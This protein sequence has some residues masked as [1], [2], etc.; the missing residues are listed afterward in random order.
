MLREILLQAWIA[1][2]R[3]PT[4]SLLTMTGIVW[5]IITVTMLVAY[6]SGFRYILIHAFE[7]FGKSVVVCWPG[8]TSEQV[9]GERAGK[10]VRFQREDLEAVRA[11]ATLVRYACLET[12]RQQ[13]VQYGERTAMRPVRG[14]CAEYGEMRSEVPSDGR[15]I[16]PEDVLERRRVVFLGALSRQRLFSG[17]PAV[18]ETLLIGGLRFTVIGSMDRKFQISNYFWSDDESMFIPFTTAGDLWNTRYAN[19]LLFT[20]VNLR[21]ESKAMAQ[22]RAAVA[23]RQRFSPTDKRAISMYGREEFRPI[24]DGLTIGMQVLML[25]IGCLTLGIGGVGVMNIMLVSV[26]ERVREIGLRRALGARRSH[27]RAQFLSEALLI[28][29][30]GGLIGIALSYGL[31]ALVGPIP[32]LGP[33]YEDDSGMGDIHLKVSAAT[34]TLSTGALVLVGV[35]SGLMPAIRASRL[36]PADALRYE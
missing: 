19:V 21:F 31:A 26:D 1:L 12:F 9:G 16:S 18:G 5:V 36:D 6:G 23:K 10:R 7:V 33:L 8:Q 17:R 13:S 22:V 34:L 32:M 24:L 35:L 2:R 27:I 25:F 14:V 29:L 15:W 30:V 4:R 28:T 20:T 3:N 11:E